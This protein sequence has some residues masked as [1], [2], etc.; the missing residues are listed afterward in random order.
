MADRLRELLDPVAS[1]EDS[2]TAMLTELAAGLADSDFTAGCPI[3]TVALEADSPQVNESCRAGYASWTAVIAD[4][5]GGVGV[6][7]AEI[8]DLATTVLATV[9]GGLL[10]ACTAR[11]TAPLSTVGR[12]VTRLVTLAIPD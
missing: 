10:L 12:A 5:L 8:A 6:P 1:V 11:D 7:E 3:A 4:W 9:E 2:V